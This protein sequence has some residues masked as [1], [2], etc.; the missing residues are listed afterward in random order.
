MPDL[1]TLTVTTTQATRITTAF[2]DAAAYRAWLRQQI[3]NYVIVHEREALQA[4]FDADAAASDAQV[5]ADLST[6]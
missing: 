1:P 6:I 3:K 4:K 2:G 5:N